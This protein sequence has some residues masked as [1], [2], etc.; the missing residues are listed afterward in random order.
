MSDHREESVDFLLSR[1][2]RLHHARA[3]MLLETLGL[4]HGQPRMLRALWEREGL[5]HSDLAAQLHVQPATVTKMVQRM[6]KAGFVERRDD[7]RDQR[8]SRVYLTEAGYAVQA[9]VE[10]VWQTLERETLDGLS[11]EE[12]ALLLRCLARVRENLVRATA[13]EDR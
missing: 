4:Y 1:V 8:V 11:P 12:C 10:R 7:P 3:H 2:C 5:T 9:Q 13:R 6:E